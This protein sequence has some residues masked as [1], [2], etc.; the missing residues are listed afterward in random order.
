MIAGAASYLRQQQRSAPRVSLGSGQAGTG[1]SNSS[2]LSS[3]GTPGRDNSVLDQSSSGTP[4]PDDSA[5]HLSGTCTPGRGEERTSHRERHGHAGGGTS[6]LSAR[7][8]G[9]LRAPHGHTLAGPA[10]DRPP[11]PPTHGRARLAAAPP[12]KHPRSRN[13]QAGLTCTTCHDTSSRPI[14]L[15]DKG[16]SPSPMH[17]AAGRLGQPRQPAPGLHRSGPN[18]QAPTNPDPPTGIPTPEKGHTTGR[19]TT[20]RTPANVMPHSHP[21]R[22]PTQPPIRA[23]SVA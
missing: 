2:R 8:C 5:P 15:R 23:V 13:P 19:N 1:A 21:D 14:T 9:R 17:P 20:H 16:S 10:H 22:P 11:A 6:A 18:R 3:S 4:G 7:H 12:A